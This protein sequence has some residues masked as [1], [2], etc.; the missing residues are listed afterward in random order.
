MKQQDS[1]KHAETQADQ[2]KPASAAWFMVAVVG[3]IVGMI[4]LE[5]FRG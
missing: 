1:K 3:V 5:W 2:E 4:L